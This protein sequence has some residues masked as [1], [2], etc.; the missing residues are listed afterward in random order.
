MQFDDFELIISDNFSKIPATQLL[1]DFDDN[2]IRII[3]TDQRL[4]VSD[5]WEFAFQHVRGEFLMYIGDDSALHPEILAFADH[6]IREHNLEVVSWRVSTYFHPD[7]NITY[8]PLPNRGNIVG[9]DA[10][11]TGKLYVANEQEVLQQF[12]RQLRLSGCFPCMV[13]F[14]FPKARAD[15]IGRKAGRFFWAPNPDI[16]ATYFILG[17]IDACRYGFF[18]GFGALGGR[19]L[20]SNLASLLSR[21]KKSRRA[22]EYFEDFGD[23]DCLPHHDIKFVAIS[24]ALA[25]TISQAR[26]LIPERFGRYEFDR[27]TLALRTVDDM[28]VDR[29]VPWVDDE[30][31]LEDVERFFQSL[32]AEVAAEVR[33][34]RDQCVARRHEAVAKGDPEPHFIRNSDEAAVSL[35]NFWLKA[36]QDARTFEWE[37][38]RETWRN[39]LGRHWEAAGTTYVDMRLYG[40]R[41]IADA[42]RI[43]PRILKRFDKRGDAFLRYYRSLGMI[44]DEVDSSSVAQWR[45]APQSMLGGSAAAGE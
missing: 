3:R 12:S 20:D 43:F 39:P 11:T 29:T 9:I 7:W 38:F 33:A 32:P 2:R 5:H 19:S 41:N 36:G 15:A 44:G 6:S 23:Q 31:F 35:V 13:N 28:Y 14:V 18:D 25:A 10:G 4:P 27:K 26:A 30:R 17:T 24:N 42:A 16:A 34:Y 8:G 1:A 22:Y 40:G 37:L 45:Q 21:G